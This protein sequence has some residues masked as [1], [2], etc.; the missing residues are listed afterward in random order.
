[1]VAAISVVDSSFLRCRTIYLRLD[2]LLCGSAEAA[3]SFRSSASVESEAP[4]SLA[5]G[6]PRRFFRSTSNY[7]RK[8]QR[9]RM[10]EQE[11]LTTQ[12]RA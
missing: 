2:G 10:T 6:T 11:G 12:V 8:A 5:S 1:M 7:G 3:G 9:E 4:Y